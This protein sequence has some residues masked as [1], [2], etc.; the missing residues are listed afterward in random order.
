MPQGEAN[1]SNWMPLQ[2]QIESL[3]NVQSLPLEFVW[4]PVILNT[5]NG[6]ELPI[7]HLCTRDELN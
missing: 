6:S 5:M 3:E 4:N 2:K 7:F 1:C